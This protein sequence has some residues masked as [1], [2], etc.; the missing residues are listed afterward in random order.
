MDFIAELLFS[1]IVEASI[2]L[3][4]PKT[5]LP[6]RILASIIVFAITFGMGGFLVYVGCT[7]VWSRSKI[8]SIIVFV[9]SALF[10]WA[11]VHLFRRMFCKKKEK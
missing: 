7:E 11:G 1:I 8:S 5:P 2:E 6:L 10:L 3:P 4:T 9:C